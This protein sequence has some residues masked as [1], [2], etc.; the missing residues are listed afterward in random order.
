M[1]RADFAE[2]VVEYL[3]SNLD[4]SINVCH[5]HH[6]N[7]ISCYRDSNSLGTLVLDN[8]YH[9]YLEADPQD[10][11]Q[12]LNR[13]ASFFTLDHE[14]DSDFDNVKSRLL[15][16]LR[17]N[18][19][20]PPL[21]YSMGQEHFT[22]T[23]YCWDHSTVL[24]IDNEDF[25]TIANNENIAAWGRTMEELNALAMR[26]LL[27]ITPEAEFMMIA[28]GVYIGGWCDTYD[29]SRLMLTDLFGLL[30]MNGDPVAIIGSKETIFVTGS[31]DLDGLADLLKFGLMACDN[32]RPLH[33]LPIV[34][35]NGKWE[36]FDLPQAHPVHTQLVNYHREI[37]K[38][39]M[40]D[41]KFE[42]K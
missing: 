40:G 28:P 37:G 4:S 10:Q 7:S 29:S 42:E 33:G 39:R 35:Q 13:W 22:V 6:E 19:A 24:C 11:A 14:P 23:P 32:P 38:R 21:F 3:K 31:Q 30:E 26:N 17:P 25:T 34:L 12:M 16:S 20:F 8:I 18:S 41:N 36:R 1:T 15:P 9:D 5:D 2:M 27:G